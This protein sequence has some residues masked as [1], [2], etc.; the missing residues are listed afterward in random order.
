MGGKIFNPILMFPTA[1][2]EA[3]E[4]LMLM[5]SLVCA[6][7]RAMEENSALSRK[8]GALQ[9]VGTRVKGFIYLAQ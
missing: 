4:D 7:R 6:A 5:K 3:E 1:S 8:R 2:R 9:S